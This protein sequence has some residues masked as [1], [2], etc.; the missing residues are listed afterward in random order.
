MSR[1]VSAPRRSGRDRSSITRSQRSRPISHQRRRR[2]RRLVHHHA[3]ERIAEQLAQRGRVSR[4]CRRPTGFAS[5]RI[6]QARGDARPDDRAPPRAPGDLTSPPSAA[7]RSRIPIRPSDRFPATSTTGSPGRRR[8]STRAAASC[9]A[10]AR[11]RRGG[12]PRAAPRSS[13]PPGGY[14]TAPAPPMAPAA[15]PAPAPASRTARRSAG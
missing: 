12:P 9:R 15:P 13:A 8:R 5:A 6:R 3:R 1:S 2:G 11:P 4:R 7:A 14:E 10:R